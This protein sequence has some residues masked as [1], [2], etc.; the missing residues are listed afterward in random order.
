MKK[1]AF[2]IGLL[3]LSSQTAFAQDPLVVNAKTLRLKLENARVRVLEAT[4]KPG[5]KENL[6]SHP[7]YLFYVIAG[8]KVRNHNVDGKVSESVFKT[9][10]VIYRDPLTHWAENIGK[11]TIH[12]IL[13]ELK[14]K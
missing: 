9:G 8:G 3:V 2:A 11:T 13:V 5:D 10:D 12:L 6:H 1:L 7:S 4:L 14:D